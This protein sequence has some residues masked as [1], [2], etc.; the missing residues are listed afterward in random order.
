VLAKILLLLSKLSA[1]NL[2][3]GLEIP[4]QGRN[5]H[6]GTKFPEEILI[7][8]ALTNFL[9][10]PLTFL[11]VQAPVKEPEIWVKNLGPEIRG[12]NFAPSQISRGNSWEFPSM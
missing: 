6:R 9:P 7:I 4:P 10:S 5:I 8:S 3:P 12:Q 1:G 2:F 11:V